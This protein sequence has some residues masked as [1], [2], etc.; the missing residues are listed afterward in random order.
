[1]VKGTCMEVLALAALAVG[2]WK[3][4]LTESSQSLEMAGRYTVTT[5]NR[6]EE[7]TAGE[8]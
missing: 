7:G 4:F 1:M 3:G 6:D 2:R 5:S 8:W